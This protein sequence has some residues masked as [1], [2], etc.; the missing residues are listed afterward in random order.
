MPFH[1]KPILGIV[2]GIG[3]GKSHVSRILGEL[4]YLV[5]DS[6]RAAHAV[7]AEPDVIA[8]LVNWYGDS[9]LKLDGTVDRR[10]IASRVFRDVEQRARLEALVHPRVHALRD[11]QM[12]ER[13]G[14]PN[15]RGF[16]WDTPLLI[17]ANLHGQCDDVIFIDTPR[18]VRLE[19]VRTT[20][21]WDEAELTRREASQL[22]LDQKRA[23]A[24]LVVPGDA[25]DDAIRAALRSAGL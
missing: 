13:A 3:A 25:S 17:E 9:I 6:D 10:A 24:T 20:R 5:I 4:G 15:V 8:T 2:G 16:V 7:Y 1:N 11:R 22:P 14:D 19:R 21:G 12:A 18:A 23:L